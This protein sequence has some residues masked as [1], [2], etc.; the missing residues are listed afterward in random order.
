LHHHFS[1]PHVPQN[2]GI[3]ND[4]IRHFYKE[5]P[6]LGVCLGHECI[7]EVFG[8]RIVQCG[9]I[10]HGESDDLYLSESPLYEG[11]GSRIK[12]ARYHSL[13]IGEEGFNHRDLVVDARLKDGTIMGLRH[14]EYPLFGVQYHPESI[15]TG[16]NGKVI[17]H[18]FIRFSKSYNAKGD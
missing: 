6:I 13:C 17:L 4:V 14:R 1:R 16:E 15:L 5:I 12:G 9:Q 11:L 3:S 7:G 2:A 18:N 10:V 8:C